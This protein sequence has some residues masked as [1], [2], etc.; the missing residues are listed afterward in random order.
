MDLLMGVPWSSVRLRARVWYTIDY[1]S[2]RLRNFDYIARRYCS[3]YSK[4]SRDSERC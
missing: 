3:D 4:P 2:V 1:V